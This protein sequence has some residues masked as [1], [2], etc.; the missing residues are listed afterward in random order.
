MLFQVTFS[1]FILLTFYFITNLK[2]Y[3]RFAIIYNKGYQDF[4]T[5]ESSVTTKVKGVVYTNF[6]QSDFNDLIPNTEVY[7]RI[8]DT[9]DYVV[10]SSVNILF[11]YL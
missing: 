3:F 8:W 1:I 4:S 2:N 5:I 10:P 6:S 9:A 11:R 7:R